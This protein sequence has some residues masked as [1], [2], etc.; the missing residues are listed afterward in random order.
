MSHAAVAPTGAR[1]STTS[2]GLW[3]TA[4]LAGV[5]RLPSEL[6][7]RPIGDAEN[8]L[9]RHPGLQA[10]QQAGICT[11]YILDQD[12]Q[13]W[14]A[15]LG[16]P[17]IQVS[18][19]VDRPGQRRDELVGPL[20]AFDP[21]VDPH[22]DPIAAYEAL[23]AFNAARGPRG[24]VVLC[25]RGGEWVS[26]AR[27]WQTR[28]EADAD[29]PGW[30]AQ[31][32]RDIPWDRRWN[33]TRWRGQPAATH[34]ALAATVWPDPDFSPTFRAKAAYLL[35]ARDDDGLALPT[36]PADL[37]AGEL[38]TI[39]EADG[40][41][42][43]IDEVVVS[44]LGHAE[45]ARAVSDVVGPADWAQF[46]TINLPAGVL[47]P[48]V[49]RWQHSGGATDLVTDLCEIG[50]SVPQAR[51][52]RAAADAS[53]ACATIT[54]TEFR[55]GSVAY[56]AQPVAVADTVVGRIVHWQ[57]T[58]IDG[59]RWITIGPGTT[60]AIKDA[61]QGMCAALPCGDN[62]VVHERARRPAAGS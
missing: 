18:I 27:L 31:D 49:A 51:I 14:M 10:L 20:P 37:L 53:S 35:A 57:S 62:W 39:I 46:D 36:G 45:I 3:L 19:S 41:N 25:R 4:A 28:Q 1:L 26:A 6:R 9:G 17:D 32:A 44:Y 2:E 23:M 11:G 15:V 33:N 43:E 61:V 38:S 8:T 5:S 34:I 16:L 48:I 52:V 50:L 56:S 21:G 29:D 30:A 40:L 42:D 12:V 59:L 22:G 60:R 55:V 24:V 47:D 58:S 13:K 7:I 54:A